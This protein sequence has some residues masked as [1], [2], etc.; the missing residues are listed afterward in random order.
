MTLING[1]ALPLRAWSKT[2]PG[3]TGIN[4]SHEV[5]AKEATGPRKSDPDA[6][7]RATRG[8]PQL[9]SGIRV[10]ANLKVTARYIG[11]GARTPSPRSFR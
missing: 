3:M 1:V 6:I 11:L 5:S 4:F 9:G 7:A 10:T 8:E 2:S